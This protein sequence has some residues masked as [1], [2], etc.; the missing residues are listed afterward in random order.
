MELSRA[1]WAGLISPLS[2]CFFIFFLFLS[3]A[4]DSQ[5]GNMVA[6]ASSDAMSATSSSLARHS[7]HLQ[8]AAKSHS[9]LYL[10]V[11]QH[12]HRAAHRR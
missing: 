8:L 3:P 6:V 1:T 5:R 7:S 10:T 2:I 11:S 12:Q 4:F 9:S